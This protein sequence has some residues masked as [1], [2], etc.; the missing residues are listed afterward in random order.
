MPEVP[1]TAETGFPGYESVLE[2]A[3]P[4]WSS[5]VEYAAADQ[6]EA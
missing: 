1:A 3:E 2:G 6:N 5:P 4:L